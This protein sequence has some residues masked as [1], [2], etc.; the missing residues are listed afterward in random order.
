MNTTGLT[1][2]GA[3]SLPRLAVVLAAWCGVAAI[4]LVG[5]TNAP[6]LNPGTPRATSSALI[7]TKLDW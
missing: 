2:V 4:K 6:T 5:A 7:G 3:G 1:L